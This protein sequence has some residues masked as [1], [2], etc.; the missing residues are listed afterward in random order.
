MT[1]RQFMSVA[2]GAAVHIGLPGV[3]I[4]LMDHENRALAA[5][6]RPDGR[7]RIPRTEGRVYH[8]VSMPLKRSLIW[9]AFKDPVECRTG[10]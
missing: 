1:R 4:K 5:E 7:P 3:F 2:G 8:R 10:S 9:V 6:L